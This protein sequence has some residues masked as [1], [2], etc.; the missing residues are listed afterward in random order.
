MSSLGGGGWVVF[1]APAVRVCVCVCV[2]VYIYI[3]IYGLDVSKGRVTESIMVFKAPPVC[4]H[5]SM[6]LDSWITTPRS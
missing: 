2:C 5:A 6:C 4:M 3:Y 1:E